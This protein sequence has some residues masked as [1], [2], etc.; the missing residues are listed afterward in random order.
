M[1]SRN[2][3]LCG[4]MLGAVMLSISCRESIEFI[5]PPPPTV[6]VQTPESREVTIYVDYTGRA[7]SVDTVEVRAR[8]KGFLQ[9]VDFEP[10][11]F[12]RAGDPDDPDDLGDLLFT[13][14]P[15]QFEAAVQSARAALAQAEAARDLSQ[16][17][18]DTAQKAFDANALNELEM[19][20]RE[21][22]LKAAI[23][24]VDSAQAKLDTALVDLSY[25]EIHAPISGR[26]AREYVDVGNLVGSGEST[27]LT[28]IVSDDPIYAYFEVGERD[29]LEFTKDGRPREI[30]DRQKPRV[31]LTLADGTEYEHEGVV[32]FGENRIDPGTGTL[33]IR[34]TFPNPDSRLFPGLFVRV[35]VPD[36]TGVQMLVP[37]LVLQRDLAGPFVLVINDQSIVERRNVELGPEMGSERI[38]N[39]GLDLADRV[40]VNGMQRAIPGRP[41]TVADASA[42]A[43]SSGP[44]EPAVD[45]GAPT[46]SSS[47]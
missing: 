46:Q 12:V 23:A 8:V 38:I 13:I 32:D 18:L 30:E 7:E 15:E 29:V 4:I 37:E 16:V 11:Q 41:V 43:P 24:A 40:V 27:L 6:T 42:A 31:R 17:T 28:R 36:V 19:R 33:Q 14:E 20:E 25:T 1:I 3:L 39:A 34:A 22:E 35:R 26:I 47:D 45:D 2:R 21:A 9:T 10:G 44:N 5:P